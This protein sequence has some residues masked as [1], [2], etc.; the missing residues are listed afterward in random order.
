MIYKTIFKKKAIKEL[1]NLPK[2][3]AQ[4]IISKIK[5]LSNNLEGDVKN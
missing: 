2:V 1:Q 5:L 3:E 4:K